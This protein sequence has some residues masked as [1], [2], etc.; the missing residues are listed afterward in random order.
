V[1][2]TATPATGWHFVNWSGDVSG[3]SN[4]VTVPIDAAKTVSAH[5]AIDT[6]AL[7]LRTRLPRHTQWRDLAVGRLRADWQSVNAVPALTTTSFP[8][9]TACCTAARTETGVTADHDL[10]ASFAID[11]FAL[12]YAPGSHGTPVA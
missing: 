1:Q 10:S 11:S 9:V 4:P 12:S 5:F 2:L 6:F 3:S 7:K 8:G